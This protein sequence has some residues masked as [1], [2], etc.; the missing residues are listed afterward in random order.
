MRL[1]GA[2]LKSSNKKLLEKYGKLVR[3]VMVG[4]ARRFRLSPEQREDFYQSLLVWLFKAPMEYRNYKGISLLLKHRWQRVMKEAIR[5][6]PEIAI[7]LMRGGEEGGQR[8][9]APHGLEPHLNGHGDLAQALSRLDCLSQRERIVVSMSFGIDGFEE[10]TDYWIARR[11]GKT[12]GWVEI[13]R[14][15]AIFKMQQAMG[16]EKNDGGL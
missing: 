14:R 7:G 6:E 5:F 9:G 3:F 4:Y 8:L 12:K 2:S 1:R 16:L 10:F 13:Q 11:L 15:R